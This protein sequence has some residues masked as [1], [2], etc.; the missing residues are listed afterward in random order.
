MKR[1]VGI[2]ALIS[3]LALGCDDSLPT[4]LR[5][6]ARKADQPSARGHGSGR[7][8]VMT[9]NVYVGANVD[10]TLAGSLSE[11]P[12]L[13]SE[14]F[15]EF[16]DTDFATRMAELAIE[17]EQM[18]PHLVGLQEVTL[19][20]AFF[21]TASPQRF[22]FL[23]ALLGALDARGLD[24]RL[25]AQADHTD[26]TLP[27]DPTVVPGLVGVRLLDADA[28]LARGDVEVSNPKI[29]RF[30]PRLGIP[31]TTI[32]VLR[33]FAAVDARVGRRTYRFVTTHLEPAPIPQLL[34]IQL[35]QA[36]ELVSELGN[37]TLPL[38]VTGDFN[39]PAHLGRG[40]AP[41]YDVLLGAGYIDVW[42]RRPP[43]QAD[44]G[45]TCCHDLDLMNPTPDFYERIDLIFARNPRG[46]PRQAIAGAVQAAIVGDE[47]ETRDLFGMWPSDHGGVVAR[48][49]I[50][51]PADAG[52]S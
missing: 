6:D 32:E 24:Y 14:A 41:T 1:I 5:I 34:P 42:T 4:E 37:E 52:G 39:T 8:T 25:V 9:R 33:G 16:V 43:G 31:G 27:A 20:D 19:V 40:N 29:H 17:I 21:A 46:I 7:V 23:T 44:A 10:R 11:I 26:L 45:F 35:G 2:T 15:Q 30:G 22:D 36:Q 48:L 13:V 51:V 49:Q 18:Q 50:P 12:R 3:L 38:I 47:Q 28:I